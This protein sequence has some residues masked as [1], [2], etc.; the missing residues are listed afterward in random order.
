MPSPRIRLYL[1]IIEIYLIQNQLS[2]VLLFTDL[3]LILD[4]FQDLG[5]GH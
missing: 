1:A 5:E 4:I 3:A 2:A